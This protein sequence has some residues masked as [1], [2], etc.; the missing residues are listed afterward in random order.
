MAQIQFSLIKKKKDWTSGTLANRP[1]PP[2]DNLSF[3]PYPYPGPP[4]S[5][6]NGSHMC[7]TPYVRISLINQFLANVLFLYPMITLQN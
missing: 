1:P 5:P 6:Q 4:H 2:S 3:L 7:I